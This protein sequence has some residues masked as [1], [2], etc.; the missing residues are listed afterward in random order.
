MR[1]HTS[2]RH[3]RHM[4]RVRHYSPHTEQ[5]YV[6]WV[7][8][9]VRFSALRHPRELAAADVERFLTHLAARG[10]VAASTQ[11]QA[12]AAL[13]FLYCEVQR[14]PLAV[15]EH[16]VRA[17]QLRHV[18][19]VLTPGEVDAVLGALERRCGAAAAATALVGRLLYGSGLRLAECLALR[20]KN[21]DLDR[22]ELV[23][24]GR[25]G[26]KDRRTLLAD[27]AVAPLHVHLER[28]RRLH[29][30]ELASGHGAVALPLARKLP[31][32]ARSWTWQWVLP[33]SRHYIDPATGRRVRHHLHPTVVQRW[34]AEEVR[35]SGVASGRPATRSERN[36]AEGSSGA[37]PCDG[38]ETGGGA[39]GSSALGG[40]GRKGMT[41]RISSLSS[42]T[43]MRSITSCKMPCCSAKDASVSRV[44]IRSAKV[45]RLVRT[46]AARTC[47]SAIWRCAACWA[48][49]AR[50][51]S[52]I[53]ARRGM[54]SASVRA[55]AW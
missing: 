42:P 46:C 43:M 2:V 1:L 47:C 32:A 53:A 36:R 50:R 40:R 39:P 14:L 4:L 35:A 49:S 27:S 3:V 9:Y 18:P 23:V 24:R 45:V 10:R 22:R 30:R 20:I 5:A 8:R 15:P 38:G 48:S 16:A 7:R 34:M 55:P 26:G 44:P 37:G 6:A 21:A 52:A 33:A 29:Q 19:T 17:D 54:S 11:K 13:F 28:V 51:C 12:L 31:E 25:K 41:W